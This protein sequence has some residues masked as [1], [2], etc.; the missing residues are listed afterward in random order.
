MRLLAPGTLAA[1]S[2][3]CDQSGWTQE[4]ADEFEGSQLDS[5]KWKVEVAE[6]PGLGAGAD[7]A[8]YACTALGSCREAACVADNVYVEGGKLVLRSDRSGATNYTTGAVNTWDKANWKASDGTFRLCISAKLPGAPDHP[9]GSQGLWPA[10]WLMPN[11]ATCDPDEGEMDIM[12]MVNGDGM[13]YGT[14]HW[15]TDFPQGNCSFPQNHKSQ[16][17][18]KQLPT[19][20]SE[21]HEYAVE[22]GLDH[23]AFVVDGEVRI[24]ITRDTTPSPVYWD[25]P[26]YLILNTAVGGGWPGSPNASTVFPAYHYIDYVRVSRPSVSALV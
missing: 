9:A 16:A 22:R 11:D 24:N 4:W 17:N 8:G 12:E 10:H 3:F 6:A 18:G 23:V 25:V 2:G 19:W 26:W 20:N 13:W 7:C 15:Q 1:S 5:G 14:Y 21:Y